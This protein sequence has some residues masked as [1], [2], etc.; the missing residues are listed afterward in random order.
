MK[1]INKTFI[2]RVVSLVAVLL[3]MGVI[4]SFSAETGTESKK[5]S[6]RIVGLVAK[7]I[8]PDFENLSAEEQ[9]DAKNAVSE[10]VRSSAHFACFAILGFL[11][12]NALMSYNFKLKYK[13]ISA[14]AF[15][16]CYSASDEIH[17][18]F[19][20]DRAFQWID[21]TVDSLGALTGILMLCFILCIVKKCRKEKKNDTKN[22]N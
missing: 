22:R 4:F 2:L 3:W 10:F 15:S 8:T 1:L 18:F 17:Q 14:F 13:A 21:I 9:E 6:G 20:P 16:V 7:I 5:T 11:S 19:V 12:L